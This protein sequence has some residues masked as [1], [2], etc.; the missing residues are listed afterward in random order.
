MVE[1]S[2]NGGPWI[3]IASGVS[4]TSYEDTGLSAGTTYR[5]AVMARSAAGISAPGASVAVQTGTASAPSGPVSDTL[6]SQPL[7]VQATRRQP[8]SG[9]V[10]TF[11]DANVLA[12][13]ARFVATIHWGDGH[14]RRGTVT[15]SSQ[16]VVVRP[17]SLCRRGPIYDQG[18][19]DHGGSVTGRH[20][21]RQH[22]DGHPRAPGAQEGP[23]APSRPGADDPSALRIRPPRIRRFF[24]PTDRRSAQVSGRAPGRRRFPFGM[25]GLRAPDG[26]PPPAG[27]VR[28]GSPDPA[29]G[30]TEGLPVGSGRS[31]R[32]DLWAASPPGRE[33][34][35][36]HLEQRLAIG[37]E[38]C[39]RADGGVGRPAPNTST[40]AERK[41]R[42]ASV[43]RLA[44]TIRIPGEPPGV[45]PPEC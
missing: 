37:P 6:T 32:R 4:A 18:V 5:Y 12:A 42:E 33:A 41:V 44:E 10:A 2:V 1:R 7:V 20:L 43:L 31:G 22:G 25:R 38:T 14:T 15:R 19:R 30:P 29:A 28:R 9:V 27:P 39:G 40:R 26:S 16:F 13:A 23:G 8:F 11:A 36:G 34:G 17:A 21:D 3:V 45:Q 35:A 24:G